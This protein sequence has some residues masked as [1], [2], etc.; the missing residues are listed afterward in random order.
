MDSSRRGPL[1]LG[2]DMGTSGCRACVVDEAGRPALTLHT[3][4]REPLRRGA[5]VEQAATIW[6]TAVDT[7]MSRLATRIPARSI[8]AISVDGT[9]GTLLLCAAD[10]QPLAPALMY[11]DARAVRQADL[12]AATAPP[13]SGAQGVGSSLS[14][15]IYLLDTTA[16]DGVRHALQQADWLTGRLC[17]RFGVSDENNALKL[18]YDPERRCWPQWLN[19]LGVPPELLPRVYPAGTVVGTLLPSLAASWG[20]SEKVR[21]V[22]GTT[23]STAGVIATGAR[24]GEAVTSLGSTLVMKVLA[25]RPVFAPEY[26]VYSHRLGDLWIVGGASN[27]GGAVLRSFFSTQE[28]SRLDAAL[29]PDSPTGLDYYPLPAPGERFPAN[30][31]RLQPRLSPRPADRAVFLQAMLEGMAR[32][33]QQGYRLL[34]RLGTP[35]PRRV[36]TIGGGAANRAWTRIRSRLL[37]IPVLPAG[38]R[39][40][41]YGAALLAMNARQTSS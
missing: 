21:I 2:I 28:L 14:K 9:S 39:E 36:L 4:V 20:M 29:N 5:G 13:A 23:D 24:C 18:G 22:T 37:E 26:G 16:P 17:G 3:G 34:A 27:S 12:I 40:A 19:R 8:A 11:N 15:L 6:W 7:L 41:A 32:I 1:F 31:P 33:E 35:A 10:G 25:P 38:Q 30:D